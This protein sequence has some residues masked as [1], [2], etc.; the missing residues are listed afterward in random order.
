MQLMK[1]QLFDIFILIL[2]SSAEYVLSLFQIFRK[3][4]DAMYIVEL[5]D[6][7]YVTGS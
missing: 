1:L 2:I 7:S 4:N 3:C 5:D 6:D